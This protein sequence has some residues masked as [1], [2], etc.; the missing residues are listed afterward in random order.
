MANKKPK[1]DRHK[2]RRMVALTIRIANQLSALAERN[3]TSLSQE[4]NRICRE[5]MEKEG[6]WPPHDKDASK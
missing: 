4:V 6:L 3:D 5:Y 2:P 1:S